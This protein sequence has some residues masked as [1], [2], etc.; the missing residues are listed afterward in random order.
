MIHKMYNFSF[1]N[2]CYEFI[3]TENENQVKGL[4]NMTIAEGVKLQM[5]YL[6]HHLFDLQLRH[7]IESLIAYCDDYVSEIQSVSLCSFNFFKKSAGCL[8]KDFPIL[9]FINSF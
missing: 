2:I 3:L 6:L 4:L 1:I 7:R 5:C 8:I 9:K